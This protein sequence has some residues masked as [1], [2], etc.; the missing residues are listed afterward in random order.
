MSGKKISQDE[1][2]EYRRKYSLAPSDSRGDEGENITQRTGE[3]YVPVAE[4]CENLE[5]LMITNEIND[6]YYLSVSV[7]ENGE[8]DAVNYGIY[9]LY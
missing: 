3:I 2:E 1:A 4:N 6:A 8:I 7:N 5:W 9:S